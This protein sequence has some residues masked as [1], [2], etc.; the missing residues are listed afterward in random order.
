MTTNIS[1]V[2]NAP[3]I[4][5]SSETLSAAATSFAAVTIPAGYL[6]IAIEFLGGMEAADKIAGLKINGETTGYYSQILTSRAAVVAASRE[7]DVGT[8]YFC[9]C[10]TSK[11]AAKCVIWNAQTTDAGGSVQYGDA[12]ITSNTGFYRNMT[13]NVT[14][15]QVVSRD[16][17]KFYNGSTL[18]VSVFK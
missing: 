8:A 10:G 7:S 13:S 9:K 5:V 3:N 18:K 6:G 14:S 2:S 16:A 11:G 17:T 12:C 1:Q 4:F 15:I